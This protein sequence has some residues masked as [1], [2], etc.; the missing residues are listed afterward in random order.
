M[1]DY[2]WLNFGSF[3]DLEAWKLAGMMLVGMI[4]Y[5]GLVLLIL[6]GITPKPK[7]VKRNWTD[8]R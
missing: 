7:K 6:Q 3:Y 5:S 2:T 4:A 1:M 8:L